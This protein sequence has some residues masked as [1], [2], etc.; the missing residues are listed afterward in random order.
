MSTTFRVSCQWSLGGVGRSGALRLGSYTL[1]SYILHV[2]TWLISDLIVMIVVNG[3]MPMNVFQFLI[4]W[5]FRECSMM[6]P[7]LY[8]VF[9]PTIR[10]RAVTYRLGWDG[11]VKEATT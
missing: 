6:Y 2:L 7:Y 9:V 1:L 8:A 3:V 5:I 10:W 4:C 11:R